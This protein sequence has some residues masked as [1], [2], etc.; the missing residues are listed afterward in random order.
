V[1]SMSEAPQHPHNVAR[2]T[3]VTRDDVVQPAP[4]PRF[5]ETPTQLA[6][7]PPA[8]GEHT[9]GILSDL[10]ISDD[11]VRRL[12]EVGVVGSAEPKP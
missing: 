10:G 6:L 12:H 1:L 4:A 3:F 8:I 7:P 2:G 9:D 11:E 5:S